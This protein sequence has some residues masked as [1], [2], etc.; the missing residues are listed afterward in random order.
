L[1]AVDMS[2]RP[3]GSTGWPVLVGLGVVV[4]LAIATLFVEISIDR[5]TGERTAAL[6]DDSLQSVALADDLRYQAYR[7]S[8]A[9]QDPHALAQIIAQIEIDAA[10][11]DPIA[12]NDGEREAWNKLRDQLDRLSRGQA[13]VTDIEASIANII[14]INRRE[15]A[16]FVSQIHE[17]HRNGIW[18]DVVAGVITAVVAVLIGIVL[19]RVIR[20]QRD[21]TR[22]HLASLDDR[23]R[24]LEAFAARVS[25]DLKGP[26]APIALAADVL[27]R[28]TAK[29]VT[30]PAAR[31]HRGVD[32]MVA[33]IDDLLALSVSGRP[34]PGKAPIGPVVR[35][36]LDELEPQLD[37]VEVEVSVDNVTAACSPNVLSQMLRNLISNSSK[38][39][40]PERSLALHIDAHRAGDTVEI[41]IA[42]NGIGMDDDAARRAFEPFFR[43]RG[44]RVAGHGLG[45]A[46]VKRTVD[47]LGGECSLTSARDHGTQV[48]IRLP[49]G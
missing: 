25:H 2:P 39:R 10:A 36:L 14:Q 27:S 20:R 7:L 13:V 32:R 21:L 6:V 28:H 29:E 37:G 3:S 30:D 8:R 41:E 17:I 40:S 12:N 38:Y 46:I 15:A 16:G 31:I 45:L 22:L 43:A 33:L 34:P 44:T 9:H 24:E 35:E 42:D 19:V 26:L 47:S 18:V 1:N 49:A 48:K 11:Y 4:A 23:A 5:A